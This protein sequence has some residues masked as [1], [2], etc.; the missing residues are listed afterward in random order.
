VEVI[1]KKEEPELNPFEEEIMKIASKKI[2][3]Q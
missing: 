1:K 2:R 3:E